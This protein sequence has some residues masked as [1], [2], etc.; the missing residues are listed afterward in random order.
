MLYMPKTALFDSEEAIL[1][2]SDVVSAEGQAL[3]AVADGL[4][5]STGKEGEKFAGFVVSRVSAAPIL[6]NF[7]IRVEDLTVAT[8]GSL[9]LVREPISNEAVGLYDLDAGAVLEG[10]VTVTGKTVENANLKVGQHVRVTYKYALTI[11]EAKTLMGDAQ[12]GGPSGALVGQIGLVSRGTVFTNCF[13]PAVDWSSVKE[14]KLG[15]NG[16]LTAGDDK[17]GTVI[18]AYVLA[19]GVPS[20][21]YPFLGIKFS[22]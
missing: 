10:G 2:K 4:M 12:P 22:A 13:D 11:I 3:V 15:E 17:E 20:A 14:I 9:T 5:P 6:E 16:M 1:S 7:Y 21:M 18:N 19:D 8:A